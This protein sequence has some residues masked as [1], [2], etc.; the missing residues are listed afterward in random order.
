MIYGKEYAPILILAIFGGRRAFND[1]KG[2]SRGK[3]P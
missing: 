2:P 3:D 1:V